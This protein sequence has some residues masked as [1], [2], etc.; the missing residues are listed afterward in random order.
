MTKKV[1]YYFGNDGMSRF[2]A[3]QREAVWCEVLGENSAA[4][5]ELCVTKHSVC[6]R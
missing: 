1:K 2:T 5:P 4:A 3:F 6:L